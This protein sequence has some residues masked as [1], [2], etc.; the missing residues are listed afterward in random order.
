[1]YPVSYAS[2]FICH[3]K[4]LFV[5]HNSSLI[6]KSTSFFFFVRNVQFHPPFLSFNNPSIYN[7]LVSGH[8][9]ELNIPVHSSNGA[10]ILFIKP[11]L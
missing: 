4:L 10:R 8:T 3:Q 11:N 9:P 7:Y 1:M 2:K 5:S 6:T